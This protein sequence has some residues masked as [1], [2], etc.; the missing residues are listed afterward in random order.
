MA[1]YYD[2]SVTLQL[3]G[4]SQRIDAQSV[5]ANLFDVLGVA[6]ALGRGFSWDDEKAG[7]RAVVL[8]DGFWRSEFGSAPDIA[9]T[10]VELNGQNYTVAG[11]MPR[12]FQFPFAGKPATLWMSAGHASAALTQRGM[13]IL[14]AVG[15][16]KPG[17]SVEQAKAD[18]SVIAGDLARQY[19]DS[20]K[21]LYSA[22]VEPELQH[23]TGDTRP[24]FRI[25]F[26][27]VVLVLLIVCANVAGLVLARCSRR[28]A[29]F[30]L[31]TAIGASRAAIVRQLLVES[32]AL[33]V[34][35]GAAGVG[36]AW[37]LLRAA[38]N[39]MPRDIPRISQASIDGRVVLFD[40]A[41]SLATGVLFGILPALRMSRSAP[42]NAMR[43]GARGLAGSRS[44]HELHNLLVIAQTALGL[45]LLVSSGLLIRSF[46]RIL[47]VPPGFDPQHL[48][49]A[50]VGVTRLK[51][52]QFV[53]FFEELVERVRS[54]P[55][56][57]S[58]S[59]GWPMPMSDNH[60]G[61]SFN[62]Q[63]RPIA[64]GDEPSEALG[65][66]MPGYFATMR[67]PILAGRDFTAR[68]NHQGQPVMM[69]N[70]A[71]ADK[72][73]RGQN[74]LGQRI[75]VRLGDDVMNDP[76]R[77]VVGVIGNVKALGLTAASEPEYYLPYAQTVVT[78][79]YLVIRTSGDPLLEKPL[80]ALVHDL[81]A[82]APVYEVE[83][84]DEYI[85]KWA[86]APRFQ[87]FVL[88]CFAAIA[89]VLAAVGL[90]GLLSYMVVQR[91]L[92]IGL[93]MALGAQRSDVLAMII[94]RGLGF[95]VAGV[96]V[97]VAA[98]AVVTRLLAGMLYGVRASD[99][100]TFAATSGLLVVVSV[101][102]SAIPAYRAA[103]LDPM[104]TLREQ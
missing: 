74:P 75:Q 17:V 55:G 90:Y 73:F 84:L 79:P 24:A 68:D 52:D 100:M 65:L 4:E 69:V 21:Q 14:S 7:H 45:V 98:S 43:A 64:K 80:R 13:T 89:L 20:N 39:L 88:T 29:E 86:A 8:S 36:L 50:R 48:V 1:A 87:T 47:N 101:V 23:L 5:S 25:L 103:R 33:S 58:V 71:F 51:N 59:A 42:A 54:M 70:Q 82:R 61:I 78:N 95:A 6:P 49:S 12:G 22:L 57:E 26:G 11:V 85:S 67:I 56:V 9:G 66:A 10:A 15:R 96:V 3:R 92:E 102:A 97:G 32:V 16:L 62:I 41:I 83:T 31:R 72:Y 44:G 94:R 60:A 40:V 91:T 99:P 30:A 34:C 46:V 37:V 35:G 27:A 77:Q 53:P 28:S 81:D 2:S 76:M 93:R 63:G 18:L 104:R 38:V 19:P